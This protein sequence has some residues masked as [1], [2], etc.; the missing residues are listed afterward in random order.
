MRWL[1]TQSA[2]SLGPAA[3]AQPLVAM[4]GVPTTIQVQLVG[5]Q[6]NRTF[7]GIKTKPGK[8]SAYAKKP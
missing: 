5:F 2:Q 6:V 3:L 1:P 7:W 8:K 4:H